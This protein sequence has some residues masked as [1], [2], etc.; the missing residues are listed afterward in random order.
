MDQAAPILKKTIPNRL[1]KGFSFETLRFHLFNVTF[2]TILGL[3]LGY[4]PFTPGLEVKYALEE[5]EKL[6]SK[7]VFL[8]NEIDEITQ[9][10]IA[11]ERRFTLGKVLWKSIRTNQHYAH[12]I[13]DFVSMV[14]NNGIKKYLESFMDSRQMAWLIGFTQQY[15]P[16]YKRI[17]VDRKDEDIFQQIIANKGKKMVAVVN[18]HHMEGISHHW[19]NSFGQRPTFNTYF[20]ERINPIGDM[21]L[22]EMLYK[23]M[24]HVIMRDIKSSRMRASPASF[25][26]EINIYHREFN[27]QYEHRNM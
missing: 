4:N 10:R 13:N 9:N 5:A 3:E 14:T 12:E 7:V 8:G 19:C 2:K 22:R 27:H 18:Q 1:V 11:H 21:K 26:S 17:F 23:H 6:N 16:E 25:T 24:Y 15:F 20:T